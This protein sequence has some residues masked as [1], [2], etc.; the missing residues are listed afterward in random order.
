MAEARPKMDEGLRLAV[1]AVGGIRELA[2]RLG[3]SP[4]AILQ[5]RRIPADRLVQVEAV[6]G[7]PREALRSDLYRKSTV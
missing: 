5:W 4:S 1:E 6:T 3:V 2:R 7:I